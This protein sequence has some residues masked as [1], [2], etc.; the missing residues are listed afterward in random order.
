MLDTSPYAPFMA[1]AISLARKGRF[2]TC[3]NP[4]VGAVLVDGDV[5]VARGYHTRVGAPHAEIEC[6]AD[7]KLKGIDPRGKT[8]VVTLEPCRHFGK[9]PPCVDALLD[10]GIGTLVYGARDPNKEAAGGA[11]YLAQRG[12]RIIGPVLERECQDL[13]ADFNTWV[14]RERPY[15]ILKLASTLDGR[16]ATR[17][18]HSQWISSEGSRRD[19]HDLR[20]GIGAAGGAILV[21]GGTFRADNPALTARGGQIIRQPLACVLTS[22]LPKPDADFKLLSERPGEIIFF[23][24]PAAA[25]STTADAL[26]K[27][28]CAVIALGPGQGQRP[29]FA[30]MFKFL[31]QEMGCYYTLCEGG[32]SLAL[33][34]LEAG[35]VDEFH[36]HVAPVILGDENAKPLF[37]GRAPLSMDEAMGLRL[38]A[39]SV[40]HGDIH[41]ILR[42]LDGQPCSPG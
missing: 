38:C 31:R 26:R 14:V 3:P 6:L 33:S 8:M 34:L 35:F 32:G 17:T 1:E 28:G 20:A 42:P 25:A 11:D 5:A 15:V 23:A 21:G 41:I 2:A 18:G 19:V 4:M 9:T 22:R 24:S 37:G 12:V 30:A 40:R 10:A 13:L 27:M 39:A 36:L 16:I 29:D 7:A